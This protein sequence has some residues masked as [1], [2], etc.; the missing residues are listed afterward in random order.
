MAEQL[1]K[2]LIKFMFRR[3]PDGMLDVMECL[4]L[5]FGKRNETDIEIEEPFAVH[6]RAALEGAYTAW[7]ATPLGC[8]AHMIL[9]D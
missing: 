4:Q 9:M 5:W 2:D 1:Q 7:S 3:H 6:V 8:V